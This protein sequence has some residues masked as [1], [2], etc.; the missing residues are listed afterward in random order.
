MTAKESFAEV[1]PGGNRFLLA[2]ILVINN[3]DDNW[4][5]VIVPRLWFDEVCKI[6]SEAAEYEFSED[7]A[8]S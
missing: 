6:E 3:W 8:T 7:E 5:M 2:F 1:Q 4:W